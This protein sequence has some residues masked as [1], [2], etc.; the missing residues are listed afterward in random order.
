LDDKLQP[1]KHY[2]LGDPDAID[3]KVAAVAAQGIKKIRLKI[4]EFRKKN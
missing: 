3:K 4:T 2:Y 1:I